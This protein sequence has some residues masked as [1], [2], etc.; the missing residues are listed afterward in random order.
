MKITDS[1]TLGDARVSDDGYL[2]ANAR[3]AR[4]GVQQ[5]LGSEVGKPDIAV[6]NVFRDETEVFSKASLDTFS[7]I[8]VT[9]D[10]PAEAVTASNWRDLAVG[11]T[12][13]EVL[14]D[15]EYLKIGLKITDA[16][17][18]KAVQDGKRELSVGYSTE[19]VWDAGIA[20][21]GTPYQARQTAIKANHI[22]IVSKGRAGSNVRIGDGAAWGASPLSDANLGLAPITK[23]T[24]GD[25]MSDALKTVVLGDKAVQVSVTDVAAIEQF[26]ADSAKALADAKAEHDKAI[27]AKD[28]DLA[29]KDAEIDALKGKVLDATALDKLVQARG[30]LIV[31]AKAIAKDVKTEGLSDA[32]IRKAAVAAA[33]PDLNL[34]DKSP[35]YIAV[36]FDVLAEGITKDGTDPVADVLKAGVKTNA[37]DAAAQAQDAWDKSVTDLNAWRKEA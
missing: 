31:T 7:K 14:R 11:T 33:L 32:D 6:V 35:E 29:K 19:L 16:A 3:T 27:A 36:R 17:A 15:G 20:P 5:Y 21:D 23:S 34:A 1:V 30:D 2:E 9:N 18:V 8:P 25:V 13:D 37:T 10:H 12:G 28:A 22:A 4:I 24:K 26:K